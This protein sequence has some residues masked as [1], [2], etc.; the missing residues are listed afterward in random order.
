[1]ARPTKL[2][3]ELL[4]AIVRQVELCVPP[5]TAAGAFGVQPS[6]YY[7]WIQRG[8]G[9]DDRM[10]EAIYVEFA[11]GVASAER[12]AESALVLLAIHK[13]R[14]TR[15]ALDILARRFGGDWREKVEVKMDVR[16]I[17]EGLTSDPD[18]L[19][20]AVAEAE[21]LMGVR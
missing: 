12:Q 7:E 1:M 15:D 19:E 11:E 20:A 4:A 6:T 18:E 9:T 8:K 17:L 2:T 3:P 5:V 10:V 14:T 21:R 16:H 13:A